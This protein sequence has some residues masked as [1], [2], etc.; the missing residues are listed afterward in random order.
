VIAANERLVLFLKDYLEDAVGVK[1]E[2]VVLCVEDMLLTVTLVLL[3]LHL[4]QDK[5][6]AFLKSLLNH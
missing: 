2:V 4:G 1:E 5:V 6:F 3:R